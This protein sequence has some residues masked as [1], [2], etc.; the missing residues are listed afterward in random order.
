M[1]LTESGKAATDTRCRTKMQVEGDCRGNEQDLHL[2]EKH[3]SSPVVQ[4]PVTPG[5]A[6]RSGRFNWKP[7]MRIPDLRATK[8]AVHGVTQV[9]R[10]PQPGKS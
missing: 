2:L 10:H 4:H 6:G 7:A 8:A 9:D 1:G 5:L 3:S